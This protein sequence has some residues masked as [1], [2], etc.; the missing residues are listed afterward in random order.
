MLIITYDIVDDKLR[1]RFSNF[2]QKYGERVQYSVFRIKNSNR[3][4]RLI[5]S[6]IDMKFKKKFSVAD[7][8]YVIST[9]K[10][11]EN[12]MSKFGFAVKE[13]SAIIFM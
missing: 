4:L 10:C 5:Q 6:E 13:D 1:T 7:S 2:L 9:C 12:K 3:V 11:C 8:V